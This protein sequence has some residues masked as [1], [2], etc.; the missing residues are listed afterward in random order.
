MGLAVALMGVLVAAAA[1]DGARTGGRSGFYQGALAAFGAHAAGHVGSA[2]LTG[3]YTPGLATAPTVVVPF[4]WWARRALRS[5]GIT[6]APFSPA[7]LA[8]VPLSIGAAHLGAAG[9]L[10]LRNRATALP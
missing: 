9:L 4:T 10:R 1:A 6:P 7:A 2:L 5:A 3:G 8:L